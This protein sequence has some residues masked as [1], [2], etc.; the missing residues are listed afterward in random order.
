MVYLPLVVLG[1]A[2]GS[3]I[4]A[5]VWRTFEQP[6]AK[7]KAERQRLSI[8]RGRSMCPACRHTLQVR[9]LIPLISWLSLKGRCRYC[10]HPIGGQSPLL[11][12]ITAGLLAVSWLAWPY[13]LSQANHLAVFALWV[14]LLTLLL[15][16]AVYDLRWLLLPNRLVYSLAIVSLIFIAARGAVYMPNVPAY[17]IAS[18]L[19]GISLGGLFW[20][21]YQLSSG[22]WIG[23]GDVRLGF[24]MGGLLGW[25]QAFL[26]LTLAAYLG[27]LVILIL[28]V[29]GRY[30]R[31]LKLPFGPLLIFGLY[32]AFLWG[33]LLIDWYKNLAG[34]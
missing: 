6:K 11:E 31:K 19:G 29:L 3:F 1:L 13:Q 16:L 33:Q 14:A 23:G 5:L 18:F 17:L 21:L 9:D 4:D 2:L 25:Q 12:V 26:A 32:V 22:K 8:L 7:N 20:L 10:S 15:A 34:Y 28:L 30:H 24:I 27:T